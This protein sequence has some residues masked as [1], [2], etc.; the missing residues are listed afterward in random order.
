MKKNPISKEGIERL[1]SVEGCGNKYWA[2][3][4]CGKHRYRVQKYGS[5]H[6]GGRPESP[7][8]A[9]HSRLARDG[10]CLIWTGARD[11]SGYGNIRVGGLTKSVHR[12][13]WE[14]GHGEIPEGLMIDHICH[15][16]LCVKLEHL[17]LATRSENMRNR[18]GAQVD[19]RSTGARNVYSKRPGKF[20]VIVRGRYF[21]TFNSLEL[22]TE[23]AARARGEMFG[24][25]AGRG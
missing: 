20:Q 5:P 2:S 24:E 18:A 16:P 13:A 7:R 25:F 3:G 22:A 14:L 15:R 23:V 10:D 19:N 11:S 6:V 1:C 12:L 4:Y 9:L 17:R 8:Q 21:G